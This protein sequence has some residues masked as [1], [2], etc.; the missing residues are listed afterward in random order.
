GDEH[1]WEYDKNHNVIKET[2]PEGEATKIKLTEAGEPEIVE[3]PAR[4][5]TQKTEYKY[6]AYGDVTEVVDPLGNKTKYTYDSHGDKEA[7]KDAEGDERK[8]KYNEDSQENEETSPRGYVTKTERNNYGLPTKVT[9][10]LGHAT[11]L[12]YD[13]NQNVE[14]ETDGNKHT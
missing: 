10:P 3:R 12:K 7:E 4:S 5:E 14:S 13:A 11:E 8:W 6:D 9:D 2:S 1:K